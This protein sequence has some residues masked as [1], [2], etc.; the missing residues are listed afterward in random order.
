MPYINKQDREK[1]DTT[2]P[3]SAG[4]LNYCI[5]SVCNHY[6]DLTPK[7][8]ANYN[9]VVGVLESAKLEF[10]RRLV[11]PYENKKISEHGEV[12]TVE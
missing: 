6:L 7:K 12:Y 10:Y 2:F 11:V 1:L 4:E 8:Y 5:T 9:E 3:T